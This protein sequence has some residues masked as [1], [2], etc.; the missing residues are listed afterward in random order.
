MSRE[1]RNA[2]RSET[3]RKTKKKKQKDNLISYLE[4]IPK[5]PSHYCRKQT[6]KLYLEPIF[7]TMTQFFNHYVE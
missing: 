2:E 1:N 7:T 6:D 5:L 3:L 4:S